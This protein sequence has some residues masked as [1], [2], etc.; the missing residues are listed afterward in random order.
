MFTLPAT[1][2]HVGELL[3][4][5]VVEDRKRNRAS[6]LHI[7][8]AL[9]FLARQGLPLRGSAL[10][11][12]FDSNL[13]QLLRLFCEFNS[14]T[15][16]SNWLQK[17]TNKYTSADIQNELLKVMSLRIL[18]EI[19][20]KLQAKPFTIMVD[21]TT[22]A[23]TQEQVVI[24]LRWVDEYLEPH[25]DFIGL[26]VTA[27]TDANSIVAIIRDVLVRIYMNLKLTNCRGQCYD[28]A[29]V[30]KGCRSG[31]AVQLTRDEPRVLFTHC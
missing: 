22:D 12:E 19:S 8:R 3:S 31:V 29:A 28:G 1:T 9:R 15:D 24:V 23:S 10:T 16:L 7:L 18:R 14:S 6:L 4:T 27:S 5:Q 20:A 26:H 13:S 2:R 17:K 25:E 11:K 21:E 30:M